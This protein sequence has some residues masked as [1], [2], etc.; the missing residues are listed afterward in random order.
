[1]IFVEKH[2]LSGFGGYDPS[3]PILM[4]W[5]FLASF[6]AKKKKSEKMTI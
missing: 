1:M 3:L 6:R 2:D 5:R 4:K